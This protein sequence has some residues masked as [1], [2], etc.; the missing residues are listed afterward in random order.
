MVP[1]CKSN[2]LIFPLAFQGSEGHV[3]FHYV[4]FSYPTR[5]TVPVLQGLDLSVKAGQTLALVGA[6]GCGK[7]T[8]IQLI[9]RFYDPIEGEVVSRSLLL[10]LHCI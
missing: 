6:S 3:E 1:H 7:S 2:L 8:T 5:A 4:K 10:F 9:E